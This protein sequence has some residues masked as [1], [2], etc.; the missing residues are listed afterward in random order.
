MASTFDKYVHDLTAHGVVADGRYVVA[1]WS[2]L[3][4]QW[5]SSNRRP[6]AG[7]ETTYVKSHARTLRT[8]VFDC[9]IRTYATRKAALAAARRCYPNEE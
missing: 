9:G 8:L 4:C 7:M 1:E 5:Q 3:H 2:D 6:P